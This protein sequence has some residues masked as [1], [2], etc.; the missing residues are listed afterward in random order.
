[1]SELE[2][3]FRVRKKAVEST[4]TRLFQRDAEMLETLRVLRRFPIRNVLEIGFAEGGSAAML[5]HLLPEA[6]RLWVYEL[7]EK[8]APVTQP[9]NFDMARGRRM[10]EQLRAEGYAVELNPAMDPPDA[11]VDLLHIDGDHR[12]PE[13]D[14]NRFWPKVAPGGFAI[15]HD[16]M[17]TQ[18]P[19]PYALFERLSREWSIQSWRFFDK[20]DAIGTGL[21]RK[22]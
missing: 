6:K 3:L 18:I 13:K 19:A 11:S 9:V 10:I 17:S 21:L 4:G 12:Y 15:M 5:M 7:F 14:W 2:E 20:G 16:L 8:G 1:M 22:A